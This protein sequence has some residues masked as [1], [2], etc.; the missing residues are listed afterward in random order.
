M[1]FYGLAT[2]WLQLIPQHL[3]DAETTIQSL[4]FIMGRTKIK[5]A[6]SDRGSELIAAFRKMHVVHRTSLS[7]RP[8]TNSLI[9]RQVQVLARG[10]RALL[11]ASGLPQAFWTEAAMTFCHLR[12]LKE[13]D[14]GNTAWSLRYKKVPE[15][16]EYKGI[17]VPFGSY[18]VYQPPT[19]SN[20]FADRTKFQERTIP[21]V[22]WATKCYPEEIG[23][24]IIRLCPASPLTACRLTTVR[25]DIANP[26][27]EES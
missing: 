5:L 24:S 12:N 10:T 2:A 16:F 19:S 6:A 7:G 18:V 17:K 3:N 21:G 1:L 4:N 27:K 15:K 22:F 23:N 20:P 11:S 8:E 14:Y 25:K 9:E 26:S 13:D